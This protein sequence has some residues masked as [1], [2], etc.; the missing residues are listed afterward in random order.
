MKFIK[1]LILVFALMAA[2]ASTAFAQSTI[3]NQQA[4]SVITATVKVKGI[5]CSADLKTIAANVEKLKGVKSCKPGKTGPT[6]TFEIKYNTELVS[7]KEVFAAIEATGG[8]KDP[9]DRPY[10][11]KK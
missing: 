8:C 4:D 1:S 7:E 5:T 11:V 3:T 10:K 6:T 2:I 9:D